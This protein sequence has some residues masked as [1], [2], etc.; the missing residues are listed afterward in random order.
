[1]RFFA[2][3]VLLA[4]A[5]N[6]DD[7]VAN[8]ELGR[9]NYSLGTGYFVEGDDLTQIG[10]VTGHSQ[11]LDVE[12]TNLGES[13]AGDIASEITHKISPDEGVSFDVQEFGDD[14]PDRP[15]GITLTVR[16]PGEYTITS[17][18]HGDEFDRVTLNFD[19]PGSLQM[20]TWARKPYGEDFFTVDDGETLEEG[21]QLAY[22]GIPLA[23][24]GERLVGDISTNFVGSPSSSVVPAENIYDVNESDTISSEEVPSLYFIEP[25]TVDITVADTVN[26]AEATSSFTIE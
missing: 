18:L 11:F 5:C 9:L 10:I 6:I 24:S 22:L 1:M 12:L 2:P 14:P 8:G 4:A 15:P 7:T 17:K 26:P 16:D 21:T 3:F 25:G 19:T 20:V 13:D 23:D